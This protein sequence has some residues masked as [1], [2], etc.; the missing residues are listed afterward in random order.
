MYIFPDDMS[1]ASLFPNGRPHQFLL[2]SD[3]K[4]FKIIKEVD[5]SRKLIGYFNTWDHV[6]IC[7]NN[8]QFWNNIRISWCHYSTTNF[9]NLCKSAQFSNADKFTRTTHGSNFSF[10]GFNTNYRKNNQNK[11]LKS[12]HSTKKITVTPRACKVINTY[13]ATSW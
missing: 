1:D 9:K 11:T 4:S 5:G 7:I 10:S 8:P 2:D 3:I 6:S 12:G 13:V